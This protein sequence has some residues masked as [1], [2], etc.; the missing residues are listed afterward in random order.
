ER[1][2]RNKIP[3]LFTPVAIS[4]LKNISL[5]VAVHRLVLPWE[6]APARTMPRTAKR[7]AWSWAALVLMGLVILVGAL[8]WSAPTK[9]R[10]AATTPKSAASTPIDRKAVAVLPFA[11]LSDD[12]GNEYFSD[13]ISEELLNVLSK[14]PGLKVSARTSAFFFKGRQVPLAEIANQ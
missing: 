14:V 3:Q 10:P 1:Q 6:P 4:E 7:L 13:G 8:L 5:P 11:N 12:K 9:I 2:V